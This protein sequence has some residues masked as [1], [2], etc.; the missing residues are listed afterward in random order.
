MKI[1]VD[2]YEILSYKYP[3]RKRDMRCVSSF[4][5]AS[6]NLIK[7]MLELSIFAKI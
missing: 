2:V 1:I 4:E 3:P 6:K 5:I 7:L